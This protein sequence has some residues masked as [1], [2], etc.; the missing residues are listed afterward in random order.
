MDAHEDDSDVKLQ[1]ISTDLIAD[2]SRSLPIFLRK[3]DGQTLRSRVRTSETQ[4]LTSNLLDPFQELPQLLDP[5]LPTWLPLL[6]STYLAHLNARSRSRSRQ[7]L[8]TRSQLLEPLNLAISKL[9]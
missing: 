1:K 5:H 9:I 4:R 3:A 8:S 2:F 6:A 7:Q